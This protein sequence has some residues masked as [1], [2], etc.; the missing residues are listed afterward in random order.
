MEPRRPPPDN[1][2]AALEDVNL[3]A[4]D[5]A[6]RR[7][8]TAVAADADAELTS[9]GAVLGSARTLQLADDANRHPP[10]L[11][12]H[13]RTGERIDRVDFHPAWHELMALARRHGLA[14]RPYA[15]PRPSAF[16]P[17][18]DKI[19]DKDLVAFANA[20]A[21]GLPMP[22]IPEMSAVWSDWGNALTLIGQQR[23]EPVKAFKTAADNI[24]NLIAQK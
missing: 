19:K 6:L 9:Q 13:A 24:R 18:R 5:P 4:S 10:E 22:A 7:C 14:N 21:N 17:V 15:D 8:V 20:G 3:Y 11:R 16:I 2:V 23:E 1:M 12:T